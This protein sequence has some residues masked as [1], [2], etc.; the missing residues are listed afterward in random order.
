MIKGNWPKLG[1][2]QLKVNWFY[3]INFIKFYYH[4]FSSTNNVV[5]GD[6]YRPTPRRIYLGAFS[7]LKFFSQFCHCR[8]FMD[9]IIFCSNHTF[10]EISL[11]FLPSFVR[12]L[13]IF[14]IDL[15][16]VHDLTE[17]DLNLQGPLCKRKIAQPCSFLDIYR[18][19]KISL[20]MIPNLQRLVPTINLV[21][22][23]N[24]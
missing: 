16:H 17:V 23:I 4:T 2:I 20:K 1:L 15:C 21:L 6:F 8:I 14:V 18:F 22:Q 5:G 11:A 7:M 19:E 24:W 10:V 13:I 12:V 9:I 3:L